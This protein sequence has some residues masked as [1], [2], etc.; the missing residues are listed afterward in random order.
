MKI[1]ESEITIQ[2]RI[3]AYTDDDGNVRLPFYISLDNGLVDSGA[4]QVDSFN[5]INPNI[6]DLT[7]DEKIDKLIFEFNRACEEYIVFDYEKITN[8][9]NELREL[10]VKVIDKNNNLFWSWTDD[11]GVAYTR[12]KRH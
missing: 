6:R 2:A 8:I 12:R 3:R 7:R 1:V 9:C 5:L 10:G 11:S 4:L